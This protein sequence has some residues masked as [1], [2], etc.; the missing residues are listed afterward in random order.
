[1]LYYEAVKQ[2]QSTYKNLQTVNEYVGSA[3]IMV[4]TYILECT[5]YSLDR[6]NLVHDL[7]MLPNRLLG[8]T[9]DIIR[10]VCPKWG[11]LRWGERGHGG[12]VVVSGIHDNQPAVLNCKALMLCYAQLN[13]EPIALDK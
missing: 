4:C 8:D 9:R 6:S 1:M 7:A 10:G 12:Q 13:N 5:I 2:R 11:R 3:N